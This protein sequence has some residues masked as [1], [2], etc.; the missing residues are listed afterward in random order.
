MLEFR[1]LVKLVR[2]Y[3][4]DL[5]ISSCWIILSAKISVSG[6]I[7]LVVDMTTDVKG[8]ISPNNMGFT[9]LFLFL[10]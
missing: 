10:Y 8:S 2:L 6:S 9:Y 3:G 1:G 4:E 5:S 7:N